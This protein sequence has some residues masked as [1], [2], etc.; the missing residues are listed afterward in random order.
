MDL[1]CGGG[2]QQNLSG[3]PPGAG[4]RPSHG[5]PGLL[6]GRREPPGS[7]TADHGRRQS[8]DH[9]PGRRYP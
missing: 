3:P 5:P 7:P 8:L 1:T 4:P 9:Q 6:H 2:H